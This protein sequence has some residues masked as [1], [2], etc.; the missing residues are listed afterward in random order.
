MIQPGESEIRI[1]EEY[2]E[3]EEKYPLPTYTIRYRGRQILNTNLTGYRYVTSIH[4]LIY[5]NMDLLVPNIP[6]GQHSRL[7][8]DELMAWTED[9]EKYTNTLHSDMQKK[10]NEKKKLIEG[11]QRQKVLR[12][13]FKIE[14]INKLG[15]DLQEKILG[16]MPPETR[17]IWLK[18]RNEGAIDKIQKWKVSD[19]KKFYVEVVKKGLGSIIQ[20]YDKKCITMPDPG[21]LNKP[22]KKEYIRCI[23]EI[24]STLEAA[25]PRDKP[26]FDNIWLVINKLMKTIIYLNKRL[27][28]AKK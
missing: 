14:Q 23:K 17:L 15:K 27:I 24:M 1:L 19:I 11:I 9:V 8:E 28:K 6:L 3:L 16:Y 5:L 10:I 18:E 12:E 21:P 22:N 20:N 26:V 7:T 4:D 2:D 25:V 13:R